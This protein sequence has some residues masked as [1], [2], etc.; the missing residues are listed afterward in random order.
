M[1]PA[2]A[3]LVSYTQ[4]AARVIP[5]VKAAETRHAL[6]LDLRRT[7]RIPGFMWAFLVKRT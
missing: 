5:T 2:S 1:A 3:R 4:A 7:S 6:D